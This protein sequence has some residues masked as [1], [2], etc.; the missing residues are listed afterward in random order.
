ML[1]RGEPL[2]ARSELSLEVRGGGSL[3][4]RAKPKRHIPSNSA[5]SDFEK[6]STSF[7]TK[8]GHRKFMAMMRAEHDWRYC[9][10]KSAQHGRDSSRKRRISK[11]I[12]KNS[13]IYSR[14]HSSSTSISS[15]F[16]HQEPTS[17]HTVIKTRSPRVKQVTFPPETLAMHDNT[18]PAEMQAFE[19]M[20]NSAVTGDLF[21]PEWVHNI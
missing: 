20:M 18:T 1:A 7:L 4:R 5:A 8:E 21:P 12:S 19:I 16:L 17:E 9:D 3:T 11:D 14:S 10:L 13:R 2:L 15:S 6:F